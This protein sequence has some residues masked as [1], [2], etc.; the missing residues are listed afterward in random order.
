MTT[1]TQ[2]EKTEKD[3]KRQPEVPLYS[4]ESERLILSAA[5]DESRRQFA[6]GLLPRHSTEDFF[7]PQHASLW[8]SITSLHDNGLDFS[9]VS[10]IDYTRKHNLY[11]GGVEYVMDLADDLIGR[12][13]S[14]QAINDASRRIKELAL[15]RKLE[16]IFSQG[17]RLC[18]QVGQ[19]P[20]QVLSLIEDDL[21]NLRRT[22]ESS[23]SGPIH[24]RDSAMML[25]ERVDRQL[26]GEVIDI[27]ITT[28]SDSLD[29]VIGGLADEDLIVLGARPSMGK[30]AAM[31]SLA[32]SG[33]K[34]KRPALIFSLEMKHTALTQRLVAAEARINGSTLRVGAISEHDY[35]RFVDGIESLGNDEIWIDDTPGLTLQEIR[36]RARTFVATH[37]RCTIF[38]DYLQKTGRR[39]EDDEKTH[40]SAVSNGLK[41][42]A[43]E[44]KCPVVALSQLNRGLETRANKRPVMS[45]LRESGAI[46]QDA[47]VIIFLYRDEVYNP[48]TKE[49]GVCEWIVAKQRDGAIGTVKRSFIGATGVFSDLGGIQADF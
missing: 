14:D 16:A 12:A 41:M 7:L 3:E 5:L 1:E 34:A 35:S 4:L 9:A 23:R 22:S 49:P 30:T 36:S 32:R 39:D 28:G 10:V 37:G 6:T 46:E 25:A 26:D 38:V 20:A 43:R 19:S 40:A 42:L 24:V 11:T 21:M 45:D 17:M 47:D 15:G 13:A 18:K 44:L 29:A 31:L 48:E 2:D 33:A 8:R 27:G